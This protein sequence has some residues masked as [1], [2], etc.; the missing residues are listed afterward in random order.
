VERSSLIF[1]H[2]K[3]RADL[4]FHLLW[5]LDFSTAQPQPSLLTAE[6]IK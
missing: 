2:P 4:T 1:F 3:L 6:T 5:D